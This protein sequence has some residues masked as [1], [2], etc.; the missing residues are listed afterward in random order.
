MR[1]KKAFIHVVEIVIITLVVFILV[2]QF[3]SV[4]RAR[5]DWE[6]AE[7][8]SMG[9]DILTVLDEKGVN[10]LNRTE[11]DSSLSA[12]LNGTSIMHDVT[13]RNAIKSGITVGCI[14]DSVQFQEIRNNLTSFTINGERA[15]FTVYR[16]DASRITFPVIYDVIILG[17]AAFSPITRMSPYVSDMRNYLR[18][19]KGLVEIQDFTSQGDMFSSGQSQAFDLQYGTVSPTSSRLSFTP[20]PGDKYYNLVKYFHRITNSTGQTYPGLHTSP[21]TFTASGMLNSG[22]KVSASSQ[23]RL[24]LRQGASGAASMVANDGAVDGNGRTVWIAEGD[25]SREDRWVLIRAA[26]AWAAGDDYNVVQGAMASPTTFSLFKVIPE[27]NSYSGV[28]M[29]QPIEVVLSLGYIF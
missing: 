6:R 24:V 10:W 23:D 11:V 27:S 14:C 21:Y 19:G 5:A 13:V 25:T 20:N 2:V 1:Q 3:S 22:V 28:G 9:N 16:I 7:L 29:Y 4:P 15:E 18:R 12:I 17:D 26:V 8:L